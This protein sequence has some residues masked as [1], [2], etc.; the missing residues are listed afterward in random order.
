MQRRRVRI[1]LEIPDLDPAEVSAFVSHIDRLAFDL[2]GAY[3]ENLL[4]LDVPGGFA[5]WLR[6]LTAQH[7]D[8]TERRAIRH[9]RHALSPGRPNPRRCP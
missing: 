6:E 3:G 7:R 1:E 5:E 4:H 9:H 8:S 2:F